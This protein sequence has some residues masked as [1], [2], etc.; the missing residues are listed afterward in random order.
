MKKLALIVATASLAGSVLTTAQAQSYDDRWYIAP[1]LQYIN[2][3]NDRPNNDD[4]YGLNIQV[5]K[6]VSPHLNA[7][8]GI[9]GNLLDGAGD[10]DN[11]EQEQYGINLDLLALADRSGFQPYVL[12]GVGMMLSKFDQ[13]I[14]NN[15]ETSLHGDVG[16]GSLIQLTENGLALRSEARYRTEFLDDA[17]RVNG[18][19]DYSDWVYSVGL[20][21]P[22]GA[23]ATADAPITPVVRDSDGDGVLDADDQ[24]PTT[25]P[26]EA[27]NSVGCPRDD[28]RDGVLNANDDCPNTA[29]NVRV[30]SRGCDLQD[31]ITLRGVN[32][33]TNSA[34]LR[35]ESYPIL[36][37]AITTLVRY[38]NLQVEVAGHTDSR[39]SDSYNQD[40]SQRRAETVRQYLINGGVSGNRLT[41]TGYGENEPVA[42]N[43]TP[44]GRLQNRRVELRVQN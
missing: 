16:I 43:D 3:D 23:A 5:G 44:D 17:Q 20:H 31:V 21:A 2:I 29:P 19:E 41:A 4:G 38:S 11:F 12:A 37:N 13:G 1:A 6:P 15:S 39:A 30:D 36:D 34:R 8:I 24:C 28:D 18:E 33:H 26:G 27:V 35:A 9:F 32:F 25:P 10:N 42:S 40:L 7:E 14:D 22:I